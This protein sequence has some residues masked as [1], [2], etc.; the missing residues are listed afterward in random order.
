RNSLVVM[1]LAIALPDGMEIAPAVI[2]TQT[3]VEVIGMAICVRV[4]PA[5]IKD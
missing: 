4:V 1:P 5:L 2:V 3:L